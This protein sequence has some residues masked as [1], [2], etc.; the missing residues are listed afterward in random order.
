MVRMSLLCGAALIAS[1][2]AGVAV[3][4]QAQDNAIPNFTFI[5]SGWLLNGGVDFRPVPGKVPPVTFDPA[6]P[7]RGQGN[8][9]GVMERMSDTEN[10]NVK[11][12]AQ[13]VMKQYNQGVLEGHRAFSS[14]SRC[15]PADP[16]PK[17]QRL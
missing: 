5:D 11:P 9:R 6:Y 15:W 12:W 17:R 3:R 16:V 13:A 4:A 1:V 14:Q 2:A 7:Q 8:Q 10:P